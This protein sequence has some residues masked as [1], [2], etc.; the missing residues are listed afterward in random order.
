MI[1]DFGDGVK[2]EMISYITKLLTKIG[3]LCIL[4]YT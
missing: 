1:A 4:W 2:G 3:H